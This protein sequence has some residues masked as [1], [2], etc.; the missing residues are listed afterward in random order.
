MVALGLVGVRF[1][2]LSR[3][4]K[5]RLNARRVERDRASV[6]CA[7]A[8]L[9][10]RKFAWRELDTL[11]VADLTEVRCVDGT[12]HVGW[13]IDLASRR[14]IGLVFGKRPDARLA[15]RLVRASVAAR[16]IGALVIHTDRGGAF[17]SRAF[18]D[19]CARHDITRSMSRRHNPWDN[20]VA[21]STFASFKCE[22][23][24]RT[25]LTTRRR[26]ARLITEYFHWYNEVRLHS[27]LGYL[28][29]AEYELNLTKSKTS[30]GRPESDK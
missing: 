13:A 9:L 30:R 19:L 3:G 2:P 25:P 20:A 14:L 7:V 5:G 10:R 18:R 16:G 12:I 21:E 6:R 17:A 29:P 11:W 24:Y 26:M 22:L 8:D 23:V 28:S 4:Q 1:G 15:C 27:R